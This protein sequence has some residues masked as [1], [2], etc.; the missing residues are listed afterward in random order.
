MASAED[1]DRIAMALP[2]TSRAPH[3]DRVA[4]KVKRIY[5]TLAA[6]RLSANLKLS[7][8]E[9]QLKCTV[10]PDAFHPVANAWGRQGWT[11][12]DLA[13]VTEAELEAALRTAWAH[14][15]PN[16]SRSRKRGSA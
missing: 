11:V 14:A 2:G 5:L 9:Q 16:P 13:A 7:H 15:Q 3:F 10:A 1:L 12:M 8:D 6:D 4:Y